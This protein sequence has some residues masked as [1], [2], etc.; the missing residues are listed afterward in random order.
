MRSNLKTSQEYDGDGEVMEVRT[1]PQP[2]VLGGRPVTEL[3]SRQRFMEVRIARELYG[4][5]GALYDAPGDA[6]TTRTT[7]PTDKAAAGALPPPVL[8]AIGATGALLTMVMVVAAYY[9]HRFAPPA[10]WIAICSAIIGPLAAS[11]LF[12]YGAVEC[13]GVAQ[14]ALAYTAGLL[15]LFEEYLLLSALWQ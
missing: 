7:R 15:I 10:T 9:L 14:K 11:W 13:K 2:R 4:V 6:Q 12:Y 3:H 5:N 8:I 1:A